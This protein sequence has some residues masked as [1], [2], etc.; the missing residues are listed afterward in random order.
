MRVNAN[1]YLVS[2]HLLLK[3][4]LMGAGVDAHE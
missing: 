4:E 1:G 3:S 2:S